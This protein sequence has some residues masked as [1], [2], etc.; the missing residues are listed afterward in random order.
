MLDEYPK[1]LKREELSRVVTLGEGNTPLVRAEY[2]SERLG[3]QVWLKI[4]GANPT[5]SFKD[6]GMTVAVSRAHSRGARAV[7]CGSTGNTSASAAAYAAKAQMRCVVLIPAGFVAAG[8]LAQASMYGAQV[9]QIDGNFD[10]ALELT[11]A[12]AS[13]GS[14]T[15]VNS[16]DP[17]RLDGQMTAAVEI[18]DALGRA[19]DVLALPVG[20]AGNITAYW[21]GFTAYLETGQVSLR[22]QMH[23]FQ[24]AG[25]APLVLGERVMNPETLAT[26]IRIGN[27]VNGPGALSA[28]R[29][30]GGA[31]RAVS[32]QEIVEAYRLLAAKEG[33][34]CEPASAI[35]VAG[36]LAS[37]V[38][39][40]STVVCV[41]TGNGL[42][43]PDIALSSSASAL[44]VPAELGA[45]RACLAR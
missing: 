21:R 31:L 1:T 28:V 37:G 45:L 4:E 10:R 35:S 30:S 13:D 33:V 3:A 22:P 23:G 36:L 9:L 43:D 18:C 34:F 8:K 14:I 20:N 32:G 44:V 40:G 29:E 15:V 39:T 16:S 11:L 27:P 17:D 5:G 38:K 7:V 2:L 42:K 25:A 12:L 6:R 26:A 41:L 19:P 24:A